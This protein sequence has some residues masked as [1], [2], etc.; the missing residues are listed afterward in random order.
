MALLFVVGVLNLLWVEII[1]TFVLAEK[2]APAGL[3]LARRSAAALI[4]A[5][6]YMAVG[7]KTCSRQEAHERVRP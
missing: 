6:A 2:I 3:V 1:A 4:A 7:R 5:G